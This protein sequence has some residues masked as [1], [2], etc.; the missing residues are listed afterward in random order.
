MR[1]EILLVGKIPPPIGGVGVH[2]TRLMDELNIL[3]INFKYIYLRPKLL[4]LI[5]IKLLTI[6][7]IHLHSSNPIVRL[8]F[9]LICFPL[10]KNLII[11]Y[12]GDLGRFNNFLNILDLL[13]VY[14]CKYPI[15]CNE[16]SFQTAIKYNSNTKKLSMFIPPLEVVDDEI[17]SKN[18][19]FISKYKFSFCTNA[20]SV[21]FD[22]NN[23]EIYG[24]KILIEIFRNLT[25]Y[26]LIISNPSN[27]YLNYLKKN[28]ISIPNNV[29]ILSENH[30]FVNLIKLTDCFLRT[31]TTDGDSISIK[32]A[33]YF[34]KCVIASDCVSR[35]H[36]VILY[37]NQD[38]NDLNDKIKIFKVSK[39]SLSKPKNC[40]NDL[41][42]LYGY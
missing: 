12:H 19:Q 8:F 7:I 14:L 1:K 26:C 35:P 30:H 24:I 27:D 28:N 32:E 36:D 23:Q 41:L 38:P 37:K 15:M 22:K 20:Y 39:K 34:G 6:E 40:V 3:N 10:R 29:L 4:P 5:F 33:L 31:T 42:P 13:S 17:V 16:R 21:K 2:L 9:G 11:S 18:K 25:N